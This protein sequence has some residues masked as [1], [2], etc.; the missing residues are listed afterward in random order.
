[1]VH[2]VKENPK[3]KRWTVF[4]QNP[5]KIGKFGEWKIVAG[6]LTSESEAKAKATK[7]GL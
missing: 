4:E 3:T 6:G 2:M 7:L 1:M 5:D